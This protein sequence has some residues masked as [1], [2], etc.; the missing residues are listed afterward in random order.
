M[1]KQQGFSLIEL[2]IVVAIIGVLTAFAFPSYQTYIKKAEVGTALATLN[3]LKTSAEDFVLSQNEFPTNGASIGVKEDKGALFQ[4]GTI[5]IAQTDADK[6]PTSGTMKITFD[7][8]SS[9]TATDVLTVSRNANGEWTCNLE[10]K[11]APKT[12]KSATPKGCT[13]TDS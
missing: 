9:L 2:M 12:P 3:G 6:E 8:D 13:Y 5:A 4:Y 7:N 1:K 11:T 10:S